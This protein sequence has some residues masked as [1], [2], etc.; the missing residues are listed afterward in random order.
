[1]RRILASCLIV[2][3]GLCN[4]CASKYGEQKTQV[5]Y[6]PACYKPIA[7]LRSGE[8]TVAK[9]TAGGALLGAFTGAMIGLLATGKWQGAVMGGAAGGVAGS[10]AGNIYGKKQ[11]EKDDNIR[12]NSYLQ[13]IDGD[14]SNLDIVSAAAR[15]SLQCYDGQFN[16]LISEIKAKQISRQAAEQRFAEISDGREEAIALLG[17]AW[18]HGQNLNQ[19]YENAFINEQKNISAPAQSTQTV[20]YQQKAATLNKARQ[21]KA[22]LAQKTA[23]VSRQRQQAVTD[24]SRQTREINEAY[25]ALAD[26]RS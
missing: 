1:M 22:A 14:I 20:S 10:V 25:A 4:G 2:V 19:E 23:D 8:N 21:R 17:N 15:S 5:N 18:Q 3:F 26:I 6:Y 9:N 12:L 11:Q 13:D 16:I 24:T 7:D